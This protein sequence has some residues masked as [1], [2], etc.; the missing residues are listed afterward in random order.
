MLGHVPFGYVLFAAVAADKW[1][2][3]LVLTHV[4]IVVGP[5]VVLL[6]AP[7]VGAVELVYILVC[8]F[9]VSQ[10]PVLSELRKTSGIRANELFVFLF[11]VSSHVIGQVLGHLEALGA[12]YVSALV[13]S[14]RKMT[15]QML[16]QL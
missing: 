16:P 15:F 5:S 10:N 13:E 11:L 14:Y 3:T 1:A 6:V 4:H 12:T 2:Q 7:F 9:V 8:F